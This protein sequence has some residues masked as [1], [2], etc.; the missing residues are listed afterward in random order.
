MN[1]TMQGLWQTNIE[2]SLLIFAVLFARYGVR[3][4]A[5]NK[6]TYLLW[7]TIPCGLAAS[8]IIKHLEIE[9]QPVAVVS[10]AVQSYVV[11]P[12]IV[13]P[14][15]AFDGWTFLA[16]FWG[17]VAIAL[18]LRLFN[19]HR[20]LRKELSVLSGG[21]GATVKE[22][23][24]FNHPGRYPIVPIHKQNFTPAAYGFLRPSIYFP[25]HLSRELSDEQIQLII[26]HEQH[27][28]SQG[29]LWLNLL[30]D[31]CVCILWFNPLIYIARKYFRHDQE[32]Y[33]DHLVLHKTHTQSRKA[34][35]HALLSTVSATH[36]V[37]LLC[38]WKS[39]HHLEE[40]IMNIKSLNQ[41]KNSILSTFFGAIIIACTSLY[42]VAAHETD[43]DSHEPKKI[44]KYVHKNEDHDGKHK[45]QK[46][47]IIKDGKTFISKDDKK[48]VVEDGEKREMT[49]EEIEM[50]EK[51][52]EQA[53]SHAQIEKMIK[54]GGHG[55]EHKQ[56][57]FISKHEGGELS[58]KD[59]ELLTDELQNI[60][61]EMESHQGEFAMA[62]KEIRMVEKEI[63]AA[64]AAN[65]ISEKEAMKVRRKLE[66]ANLRLERDQEKMRKT[67][68]Q[69]RANVERLR[70]DIMESRAR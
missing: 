66:Q 59:I 24:A 2:F 46:I 43:G 49:A 13:E 30:W 5:V 6:N 69:T 61:I 21:H 8:W 33:C 40:R 45:I 15:R 28:I 39:K 68:E 44:Y 16:Y 23:R 47:K 58:E 41:H 11:T 64:H 52:I 14:A 34:Y 9:A 38:P 20:L 37:S 55:G 7:M 10:Q 70:K 62:Q 31:I 63:E 4:L 54:M 29:H 17:V 18:I 53:K 22:E 32:L 50:F 57:R 51:E 60:E 1:V 65:Q 19:Q 56:I 67:M 3:Y 35:G 12:Y 48:F 27:H 42:G 36:S 26:S 25:V